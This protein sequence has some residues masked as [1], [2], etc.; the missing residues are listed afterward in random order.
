[1]V[2]RVEGAYAEFA[3]I[4]EVVNYTKNVDAWMK[5]GGRERIAA[6]LGL[7]RAV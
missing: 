3:T 7:Q 6:H 2:A 5:A 4:S 1:V